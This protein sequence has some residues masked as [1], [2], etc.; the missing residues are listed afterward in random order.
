MDMKSAVNKHQHGLWRERRLSDD[1]LGRR[2]Q[3]A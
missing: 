1:T 3:V 2:R